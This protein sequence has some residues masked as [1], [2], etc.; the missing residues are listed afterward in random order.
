MVAL[1]RHDGK[2]SAVYGHCRHQNGPLWEGRVIDGCITCPWHG[3]Q[4]DPANGCSP[5][6]FE[7][8]LPTYRVKV[9][10]NQVFLNPEA[11]PPG[12]PV[13]PARIPD[14]GAAHESA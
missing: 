1:F 6:P 8:T 12:T 4:Y 3:Y 7:E 9:E 5:P 14:T 2:F 10:G 13:A 11:L